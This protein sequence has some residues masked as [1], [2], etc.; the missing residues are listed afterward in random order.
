M[1]V[2]GAAMCL[3][4]ADHQLISTL[5]DRHV[6]VVFV[7][8]NIGNRRKYS[9]HRGLSQVNFALIYFPRTHSL[10]PL[11]GYQQAA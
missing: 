11:L 3:S 2:C 10:L 5:I 9:L 4:L 8:F 6:H 7:N 1:A